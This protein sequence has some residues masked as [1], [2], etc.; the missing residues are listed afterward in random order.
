MTL[1]KPIT[2]C[3][4]APAL[5]PLDVALEC[6]FSE[7]AAR[8]SATDRILV[9]VEDPGAANFAAA[10]LPGL[11][12]HG[13]VSVFASG[14][15]ARQFEHLNV[16]S[17]ELPAALD[18]TAFLDG[19]QAG[20]LVAG[21]SEDADAS[22][23]G[24]V[25]ACRQKNI[26]TLGFVDGPANLDRRF[27]ARSDAPLAF[28]PDWVLVPSI[29]L[30]EKLCDLGFAPERAIAIEHPHF[31]NLERE[32]TRLDKIGRAVLRARLFPGSG[33][34]QPVIVCLAERSDGLDPAGF[35]RG[36]DYSLKGRGG[37]DRRTNIVLEEVLDVLNCIEPRPHVVLRLHPKNEPDEFAALAHEFDA[38]SRDEPVL[39][40]VYAADL[41]V[42]L[43]TIL[44]SEAAALGRPVLSVVPREI[45][46][47]WLLD[48]T[49]KNIECVSTRTALANAIRNN[50]QT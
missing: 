36:T 19:N 6:V 42:G 7:S 1:A 30:H 22:I 44:L 5:T 33:E 9:V 39:D 14:A 48:P 12:R 20:L 21:T 24:L 18:A 37:D 28:A 11:K 25:A 40:L 47:S 29:D 10:M 27:R 16:P 13:P 8:R 34:N 35:R 50:L 45:E 32:R 3:D 38:I 43:T 17:Q 15:G 4:R 46:K 26:A 49:G 31:A 2:V 23:H 41:V